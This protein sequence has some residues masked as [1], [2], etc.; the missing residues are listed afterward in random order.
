MNSVV[1]MKDVAANLDA[2]K[3]YEENKVETRN[4][5]RKRSIWKEMIKA[6]YARERY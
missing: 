6:K 2:L 3:S 1:D 4:M 5:A